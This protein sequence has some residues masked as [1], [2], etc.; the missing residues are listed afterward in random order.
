VVRSVVLHKAELWVLHDKVLLYKR[1]RVLLIGLSSYSALILLP[2][3]ARS[4]CITVKASLEHPALLLSVFL[5]DAGWI[6]LL[7]NLPS[8]PLLPVPTTLHPTLVTLEYK[9]PLLAR[10][11]LVSLSKGKSFAYVVVL[12]RRL[13]AGNS[14]MIPSLLERKLYPLFSGTKVTKYQGELRV[15]Y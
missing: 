11:I 10:P 14:L 6:K 15:A 12:K 2:E 3:Q 7:S 1:Q 9:A 5:E 13:L 4:L 8:N